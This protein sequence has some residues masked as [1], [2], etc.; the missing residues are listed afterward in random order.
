MQMIFEREQRRE[1]NL[2]NMKK[3]AEKKPAKG[4]KEGGD[5]DAKRAA[6]L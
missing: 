2:E 1:K 5:K 6:K 4:A 3:L